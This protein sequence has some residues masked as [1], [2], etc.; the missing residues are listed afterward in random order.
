M[1]NPAK[2]IIDK[3][4]VE[5]VVPESRWKLGWKS[6]AFWAI[7]GGTLFLGA[8]FFSFIILNLLDIRPE[9]F[10]HLRLGRFAFILVATAPYLWISLSILA[11][12][13]GFMAIRR[14]KRGYRYSVLFATSLG[15]LTISV[16]G[17]ALHISKVNER[18]GGGI[19]HGAPDRRHLAFPIE[20]RWSRPEEKMLGGEIVELKSEYFMLINFEDETWEV[21]YFP[22]TEIRVGGQLEAGM[23]VGIIGEKIDERKFEAEFIRSFPFGGF[24]GRKRPPGEKP[25]FMRPPGD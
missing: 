5:H 8:L 16:L 17:I 23:K 6:Y 13:S 7:W 18:M 24:G 25:F 2:K 9:I 11:L 12:V 1:D 21:R 20:K 15:V 22:D 14:T 3:I 4:K 19:F 10:H